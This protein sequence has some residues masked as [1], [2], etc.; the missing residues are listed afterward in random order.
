MLKKFNT[1]YYCSDFRDE[2]NGVFV[3]GV[4]FS[5]KLR[6]FNE[7][8]S[9]GFF[10]YHSKNIVVLSLNLERYFTCDYFS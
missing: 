1:D 2:S 10:L 6:L 7:P 8:F 3:L 9:I 5:D 4:V